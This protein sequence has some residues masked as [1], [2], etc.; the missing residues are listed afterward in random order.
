MDRSSDPHEE[1]EQAADLAAEIWRTLLPAAV[2][3]LRRELREP[4]STRSS[5]RWM[6]P[7]L[8]DAYPSGTPT[9]DLREVQG[10]L[11]SAVTEFLRWRDRTELTEH[12]GEEEMAFQL[13]RIT[14]NRWQRRDRSDRKFEREVEL[15]Q[16]ALD[17]RGTTLLSILADKSSRK[18]DSF[19]A[20]SQRSH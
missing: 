6:A 13:I 14:Y 16:R 2:D 3:L 12:P 20:A 1:N 15:G 4:R 5:L 8:Y 17:E 18:K 19:S 7:A 11:A 10:A 9:D